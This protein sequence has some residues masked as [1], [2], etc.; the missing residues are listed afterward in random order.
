MFLY[1]KTASFKQTWRNVLTGTCQMRETANGSR[2]K[3]R[4]WNNLLQD[5]GN[6]LRN[7]ELRLFTLRRKLLDSNQNYEQSTRKGHTEHK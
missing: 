1:D 4:T 6:K 2:E 3:L 7:K 5:F